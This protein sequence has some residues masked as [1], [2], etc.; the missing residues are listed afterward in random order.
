MLKKTCFT[1]I[2][3]LTVQAW[4]N[5][6]VETAAQTNPFTGNQFKVINVKPFLG[7]EALK[8]NFGE[9]K[10]EFNGCSEEE[11]FSGAYEIRRSTQK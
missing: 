5:L 2:F 1:L 9:K 7:D 8:I 10:L 3:A 6:Q 11:K 4:S